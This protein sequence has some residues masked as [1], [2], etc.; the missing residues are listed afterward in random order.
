TASDPELYVDPFDSRYNSSADEDDEEEL[1]STQS[2]SDDQNP[3]D[4]DKIPL[5]IMQNA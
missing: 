5:L 1:L 2:I 3:D 4:E